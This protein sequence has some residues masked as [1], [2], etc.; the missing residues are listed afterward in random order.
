MNKTINKE[1]DQSSVHSTSP[2]IVN[3]PSWWNSTGSQ[4]P[5]SCLSKSLTLNLDSSSQ[6]C[7]HVKQLGLQL[8]DQDSSSTQSTGQSHHE[9]ATMGAGNPQGQCISI[10]SGYDETNG[11]RAEHMK[12]VLSL[13]NHHILVPPPHIDFSQS[14]AHIPYADP[15][16][17]GVLAAYG[18]TPFIHPQMLGLPPARVPLPLELSEDEPI[19]VNAKQYRGILRRRQSRAKLEAQNKLLKARKPY[20]HESRHLHAMKR[21]R[22]NGGRFL[23]MKQ[24]QQ[25]RLTPTT[26][27]QIILDS[28][29]LHPGRGLSE[30]EVI[31]SENGN[32]GASAMSCSDVTSVSNNDDGIFRQQDLRFSTFHSHMG[33]TLQ[34]NAIIHNGS[35]HRVAGIR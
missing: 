12:S 3:C 27:G 6:H 5:Q 21:A 34:G 10:Q 35:L 31:Q 14:I 15:Y 25:S 24:L 33:E 7:H 26:D 23:N 4:I 28:A 32:A 13:A 19:Y 20:L 2:C 22:G 29:P 17:G 30:S 18:P 11:R 8:Q 1:S 9:V 16:F